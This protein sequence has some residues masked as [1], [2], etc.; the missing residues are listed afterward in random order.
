MHC[1][2][3]DL[4]RFS[5]NHIAYVNTNTNERLVLGDD[6]NTYEPLIEWLFK[7]T[8]GRFVFMGL[9]RLYFEKEEDAVAFKLAHDATHKLAIKENAED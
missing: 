3:F 1:F 2:E 4:R 5:S 6:S 7:N 9:N 8:T